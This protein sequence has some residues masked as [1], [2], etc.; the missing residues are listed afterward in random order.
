VSSKR[1]TIRGSIGTS[2]LNKKARKVSTLLK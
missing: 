1:E 2:R